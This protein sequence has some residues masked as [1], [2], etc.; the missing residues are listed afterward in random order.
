V[1]EGWKKRLKWSQNSM[2][3]NPLTCAIASIALFLGAL[4]GSGAQDLPDGGNIS[5]TSRLVYV[6]VVVRDGRG[7]VVRGLTQQDFKIEGDGH[8]QKIDFF[9]AHSYDEVS[10]KQSKSAATSPQHPAQFSNVAG[11]GAPSG[12]INI[13]LFDLLNTPALD[14]LY[15]RRQLLKFLMDLPPGQRT[16]L[17][18]LADSLKMLQGFTDSSDRLQQ[19]ARL[20]NPRD[21]GLIRSQSETMR[22]S[23]FTASLAGKVGAALSSNL[24]E[25]DAENF[26]R[27][28][29]IT[30][31]ALEELAQV[32]PGAAR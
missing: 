32:T 13:I 29:R 12:A 25:E 8:A 30:I 3:R 11:Q 28:A 24:D 18:I 26:G 15:A 17:F 19:A 16:A 4:G 10:A 6:D 9:A 22:D 31:L 2:L 7:N 21:F 27:R 14:Q 5:I 20:I 1:A 23:D